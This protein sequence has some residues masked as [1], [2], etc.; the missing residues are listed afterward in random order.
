MPSTA[1][2]ATTMREHQMICFLRIILARDSQYERNA[3]CV[4]AD[5]RSRPARTTSGPDFERCY[6]LE[7]GDWSGPCA[8]LST[9]RVLR[10]AWTETVSSMG[11]LHIPD[12]C[13][14]WSVNRTQETSP[15]PK[16]HGCVAAKLRTYKPIAFRSCQSRERRREPDRA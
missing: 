1:A 16:R 9:N 8:I 13:F 3:C 2:A 4:R 14:S 10:R 12:T 15:P 11:S 5:V 6:L 7:S